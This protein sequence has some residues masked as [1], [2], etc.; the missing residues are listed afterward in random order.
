MKPSERQLKSCLAASLF[1][2]LCIVSS[3][4][5]I[6]LYVPVTLQLLVTNTAMLVL[7][8]KWAAASVLCYIFLGLIGIGTFGS[9][10]GIIQL[11]SVSFGY[12]IGFLL[13]AYLG[14]TVKEKTTSH[15]A[16]IYA[17]FVNLLAVYVCGSIYFL[18]IQH[19]WLA[20]P[21]SLL[22]SLGISV[23]PF[24]IPDILK[25]LMSIYIYRRIKHTL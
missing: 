12:N 19:L 24:I 6:P 2:A 25:I 18:L 4:I 16:D 5:K 17:S 1:T 11:T 22:S 13:G 8:K 10:A 9:G 3:F 20:Q 21:I 7:S 15:H 23:I 14:G